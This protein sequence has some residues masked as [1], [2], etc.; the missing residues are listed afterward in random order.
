[1]KEIIVTGGR[2]FTD[3]EAVFTILDILDPDLIIQGGAKGADLLAARWA[4][5]RGKEYKTYHADWD[6]HGKAA[7]HIRNR[8]MLVSHP[9]ATVVAFQGGRGTANCVDQATK[10]KMTV[11]IIPPRF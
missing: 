3:Q 5:S 2:D 11:H 8:K 1:M 6:E 10:L 7:G 9:D 4:D